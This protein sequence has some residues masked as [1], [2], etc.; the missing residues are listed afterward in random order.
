MAKLLAKRGDPDQML[1]CAAYDLGLH[2]LTLLIWVQTKLQLGYTK[3][4]HGGG[5]AG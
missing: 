4:P 2:C 3:Y 1:Q 5:G